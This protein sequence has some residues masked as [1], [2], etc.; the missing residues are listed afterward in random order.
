MLSEKSLRELQEQIRK[1]EF[2]NQ[3]IEIPAYILR[4]LYLEK[5]M[6]Q[7]EIAS[8]FGTGQHV[9]HKYIHR[10][11]IA[12]TRS[13]A[14]I[15]SRKKIAEALKARKGVQDYAVKQMYEAG[16]S[17]TEIA[18]AVALY[19]STARSRLLALGV[20]LR[21]RSAALKL[22]DAKGGRKFNP[23]KG[24]ACYNWKGGIKK[25]SRGYILVRNPEH[26]R[27]MSDGYV[28]RHIITWESTHKAPLPEG[29]VI[30]H[31]NG[32]KDD[33]RPENL[34]AMPSKKHKQLISIYKNR[35]RQ[36]ELEN[37][38]LLEAI[39]NNQ[40]LFIPGGSFKDGN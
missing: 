11:G 22:L 28:F 12:R 18:D 32:I 13:Q 15:R 36:L 31:L 14:M 40:L 10:F 33:D 7:Q 38:K 3:K 17:T 35:I 2:K 4:E 8:L 29:W 6:T 26:P 20:K 23:Y 1:R 9:I 21:S 27:A 39:K 19:A 30:H 34:V 24:N 37:R 5:E 25:D 16:F